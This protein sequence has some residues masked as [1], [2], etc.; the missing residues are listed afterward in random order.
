MEQRAANIA[1]GVS[2]PGYGFTIKWCGISFRLRIKLIST[3]R[4]IR[5]SQEIA[6]ISDIE[7][8]GGT[9]F[10][11]LMNHVDD[12]RHIARSIAIATGTRF[13][14]MVTRAIMKLPLK[15][16]NILFDLVREQSDPSVFFYTI[17]SA[18]RVSLM[19]KKQ[20]E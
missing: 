20:E 1:L 13:V 15:D 12:S 4:L 18:K 6:K 19:K 17:I 11:A 2:G 3:E 5:I 9:P 8:E 14:R 16:Q 7:N 10:H